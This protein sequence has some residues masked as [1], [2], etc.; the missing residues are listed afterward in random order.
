MNPESGSARD[1]CCERI[2]VKG[3]QPAKTG[4]YE[5]VPFEGREKMTVKELD[6]ASRHSAGDA[7]EHGEIM[8]D[9]PRPR[10]PNH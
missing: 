10:Q 9:A 5:W 4:K 7:R 1:E 2:N 6:A 8:K 3:N